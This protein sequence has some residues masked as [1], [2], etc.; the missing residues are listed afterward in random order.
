MPKDSTGHDTKYQLQVDEPGAPP[1]VLN[2]EPEISIEDSDAESSGHKGGQKDAHAVGGKRPTRTTAR[3]Q[4]AKRA[5]INAAGTQEKTKPSNEETEEDEV[6]EVL[7]PPGQDE[8]PSREPPQEA[9][10]Q[11]LAAAKTRREAGLAAAGLTKV[12]NTPQ[13]PGTAPL[14]PKFVFSKSS[15]LMLESSLP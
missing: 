7:L 11:E 3:K 12:A 6:D 2:I 10:A 15:R 1:Q 13:L 4:S 8:L 14:R 5:K 9:I